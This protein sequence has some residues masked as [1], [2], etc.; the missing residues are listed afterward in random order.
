V[1]EAIEAYHTQNL[2]NYENLAGL[3]RAI[4]ARGSDEQSRV[5][6]RAVHRGL[7]A[8]SYAALLEAD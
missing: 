1:V 8:V 5:D 4:L 7:F 2:V 6:V 3:P